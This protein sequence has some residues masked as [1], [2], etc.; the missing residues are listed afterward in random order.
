VKKAPDG[1]QPNL[2]AQDVRQDMN[3]LKRIR[4]SRMMIRMLGMDRTD[5]NEEDDDDD[6]VSPTLAANRRSLNQSNDPRSSLLD[7]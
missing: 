6:A 3:I 2:S 4:A 1:R 5:E 7:P